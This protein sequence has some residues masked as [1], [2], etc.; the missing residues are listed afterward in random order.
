MKSIAGITKCSSEYWI[1]QAV[2][3]LFCVACTVVAVKLAIRDQ[4]LKIKYGSVNLSESDIRYADK[5]RLAQLLALGF[6]G[7]CLAAAL[8]LG[9]GSI[10]NPALLALGVPPKVTA[11]TG[12]YLIT[13]S[14]IASTLV[15][16]LNDQLDIMYGLWIS[17]WS[18]VGMLVGFGISKYYMKKTGRQSIIVW[19]LV[20]M[21]IFSTVT[22]PISGALSLKKEVAEGLD[23][24]AFSSLC[25]SNKK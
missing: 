8:G 11:A 4:G 20:A 13:F 23:L 2:F 14:K 25:P 1:T 12:L 18:C 15:Y 24:W 6:V 7:G 16:F 5:K 10:Y 17:F 21:F 3:I 22:T 19:C 9:G